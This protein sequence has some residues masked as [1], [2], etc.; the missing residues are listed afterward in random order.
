[1]AEANKDNDKVVE[2]TEDKEKETVLDAGGKGGGDEP[3][4]DGI[5]E[6]SGAG[7]PSHGEGLMEPNSDNDG[8]AAKWTKR[9]PHPR[10]IR[11]WCVPT[12]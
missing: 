12:K 1:M 6:L 2:A 9:S 7:D 4:L 3:D 10:P 11:N 8:D 5:A